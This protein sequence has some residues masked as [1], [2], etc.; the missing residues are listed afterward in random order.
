M[1]DDMRACIDGCAIATMDAAGTEY[2]RG[3]VVVEGG[4]IAAVGTGP[5]PQ[6]VAERINGEGCL[7]TPGLVNCHH[8]LYQ[9]LTR[10]LAQ[11]AGLFEWLTA[12]YPVWAHIDA[13][14]EHDAATAGL[15]SL[16]LSGC[17]TSSDHHYVFPRQ[18]GDLFEASIA[19]A[20]RTGIRFHA[21]RGAMDLGAS[22]GGLPPD[23]VV[24]TLDQA[25]DATEEAVDRYHDPSFGAM[26]RVAVAPCSPFSATLEL[27]RA[28]A[29]LARHKGVRLH[30]HLAETTEEED[31]CRERFGKG[32]VDLMDDLGWLGSD[33]WLAHCVHLSSK[34]VAAL[35][36]TG[37]GVAHCPSSNGRLGAGIAPVHD[38]VTAGVTVGLGVD[39]GASNETGELAAELRAALLA[40]RMR[41]GPR[42]LS[43]RVALALGTRHGARCLGRQDEIGSL[44]VG[45][46]ADIAL[47][48]LDDLGHAGIED[49]VAALVLGPAPRVHHLLVDGRA[50]VAEGRPIAVDEEEASQALVK[51]TQR[52]A[53][54]AGLSA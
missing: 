38:L 39:G 31:F 13:E 24:E 14:M 17:T 15:L 49:P 54:R 4:R 22:S 7:A 1:N 9:W 2:G 34:D 43:A 27:M 50:V 52:L 32:P 41:D 26:V 11:E 37:T 40:A 36:D 18:A 23:E 51:S 53:E 30:T 25:I 28:S 20:Q 3:H 29:D 5:G 10:G 19:A 42:A 16:Q 48:K 46:A 6:D 33:V 12:L 45:K 35:A 21:C 44:E 47:W 8:H